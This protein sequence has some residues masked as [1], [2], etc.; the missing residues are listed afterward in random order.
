MHTITANLDLGDSS[1]LPYNASGHVTFEGYDTSKPYP[2]T[3]TAG[4]AM[5]VQVVAD[6]PKTTSEGSGFLTLTLLLISRTYGNVSTDPSWLTCKAHLGRVDATGDYN[7][8][9]SS[10]L[11]DECVAA[12]KSSIA[13]TSIAQGKCWVSSA[14]PT[15]CEGRLNDDSGS[16]G[17]VAFSPQENS[18]G[19]A[20]MVEDGLASHQ[21]GNYTAYDRTLQTAYVSA[22][23]FM[24]ASANETASQ[25]SL[26]CVRPDSIAPGSRVPG[27][28]PSTVA[29]PWV[30]FVVLLAAS[31]LVVS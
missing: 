15:E 26:V 21:K 9:C 11:G 16:F 4:W 2:G 31:V 23:W 14:L 22:V 5:D 12:L 19:F 1:P 24:P 7:K 3:L 17:P 8:P 25:M 13:Q 20:G 27:H 28:A 29:T 30:L 18:R 6:S 10:M